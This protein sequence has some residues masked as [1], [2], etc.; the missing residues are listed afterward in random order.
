MAF[1]AGYRYQLMSDNDCIVD[2][3]DWLGQRRECLLMPHPTHP[4]PT[5]ASIYTP[6]GC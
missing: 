2:F 4:P 3:V 5:L 6:T 1:L